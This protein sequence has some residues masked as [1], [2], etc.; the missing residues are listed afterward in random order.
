VV[1]PQR[2]P[3]KGAILTSLTRFWFDLLPPTIPN[4]LVSLAGCDLPEPFDR[5]VSRWGPRFMLVKKLRMIPIECV[6][7]GYVAGSGWK[8]YQHHGTI[9][10]LALPEGLEQSA[11]LPEPIF[12]PAAK[13]QVGHDENISFE[14]ASDRVGSDLMATLRDLSMEIFELGHQHAASRGLILADTKFEFGLLDGEVVPVLADEVLTADSSR[15][16]P[17]ENYRTGV[18]PESFDKQ[19]VRDYLASVG[20]QGDGDPP[21]LPEEVVEGT[22]AR[23]RELFEL[24]TGVQWQQWK[25]RER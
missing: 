12:T 20:W 19:Y 16:W 10:G 9:C 1:L 17:A 14:A 5:E 6:V 15:F 11:R 7:R 2:I 21:R 24:I 3:D 22:A 25:E 18:S 13:N 23:Y 4:H 8:E